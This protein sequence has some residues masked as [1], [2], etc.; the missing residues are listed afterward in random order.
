MKVYKYICACEI[1]KYKGWVIE[2]VFSHE[3]G[4]DMLIISRKEIHVL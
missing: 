1:E 3:D 2:Y 4:Q